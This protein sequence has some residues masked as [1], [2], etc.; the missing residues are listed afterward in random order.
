M[1]KS[2]EI[3]GFRGIKEGKLEDLTPLVVLVG[4]NGCGKSTVLEASLLAS[5]PVPGNAIVQIAERIRHV[6]G[7]AQYLIYKRQYMVPAQITLETD[8][9]AIRDIQLTSILDLHQKTPGKAGQSPS[10][11]PKAI[12]FQLLK[13]NALGTTGIDLGSIADHSMSG[14]NGQEYPLPGVSTIALIEPHS[15]ADR[16]ALHDLFTSIMAQGR[17]DEARGILSDIIPGVTNVELG[18]EGGMPVLHVV[19][20]DRSVPV[21]FAGTGVEALARI[22]LELAAMAGGVVLLEEPEVHQHPGAVRQTARA[23]W[24]A[25]RRGIQVILST[26][27]LELIDRLLSE[28]KDDEELKSLSIYRMQLSDGCLRTSHLDGPGA[29]LLRSSI[30]EDLR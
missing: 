25:V 20:G 17:R 5:H 22:S 12:D 2:I 9:Q 29:A 10:G 15:A 19:Y 28:S 18:S 11:L 26:H 14:G 8:A 21:Q 7:G 3:K 30:E 23:I 16:T 6:P 24:A 13:S 27:S 4:P 1:I